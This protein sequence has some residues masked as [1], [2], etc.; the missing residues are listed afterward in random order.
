[1]KHLLGERI[2]SIR[3]LQGFTQ[4]E[5]AKAIGVTKEFISMV[6]AGKR[7]P[8]LKI[9]AKLAAYFG[10]DISYFLTSKEEPFV[11]IFRSE[12]LGKFERREL[13]K[14]I[15]LADDY[16]FLEE[17]TGEIPPLAPTY[18]EPSSKE[19]KNLRLLYR[20]AE[21]LA[22]DERNR[23]RLGLEPIKDIFSLV[24]SQGL[25]VIRKEMG[26]IKLDGI[27]LFSEE[28]GAFAII[29]ASKTLGRQVFTTAHEYCHYLKDRDKGYQIDKSVF[30]GP[31]EEKMSPIERIANAFASS[32]LMPREAICEACNEFDHIGPEEVI[33]LKRYFGVSYQAMVYRLKNLNC[34]KESQK[35]ELLLVKPWTLEKLIFGDSEEEKEERPFP[36]PERY[37]KLALDAYS[38]G[39]ISLSKL[40]ELIKIDT[41]T[42]RKVLAEARIMPRGTKVGESSY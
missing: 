17:I 39:K 29:N 38:R 27:F 10:R 35:E 23:L 13:S 16:S 5:V 8:S 6:E 37:L 14:I 21:K 15:K 9:M 3:E 32:F 7:L 1:V 36:I 2:K 22:E 20:Y 34:I 42:L 33:Y 4:D 11:T 24:E 31:T 26:E 41:L 19:L 30:E 28:R 40:A 18:P 12:E 25:H